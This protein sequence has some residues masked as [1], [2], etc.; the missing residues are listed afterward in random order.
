MEGPRE[1]RPWVIF[2]F[3][4]I[5]CNLGLV[6]IAYS[7]PTEANNTLILVITGMT[8]ILIPVPTFRPKIQKLTTSGSS[9]DRSL[10]IIRQ[11]LEFAMACSISFHGFYHGYHPG[12]ELKA[13]KWYESYDSSTSL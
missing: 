7:L 4:I 13:L 1:L 11:R 5:V 12:K 8:S 2:L 6:L 10:L 3:L 9:R